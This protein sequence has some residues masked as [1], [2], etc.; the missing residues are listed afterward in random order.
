MMVQQFIHVYLER[1]QT[2]YT[3]R[4]TFSVKVWLHH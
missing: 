4:W 1:D 3:L 2:S